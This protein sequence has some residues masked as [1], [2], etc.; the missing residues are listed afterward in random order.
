MSLNTT[1]SPLL[2][3]TSSRIVCFCNISCLV[4]C[5]T[6]YNYRIHKFII[7]ITPK[8]DFIEDMMMFIILYSKLVL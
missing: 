7:L 2:M 6:N 3:I 8:P 1:R 5:W 4:N